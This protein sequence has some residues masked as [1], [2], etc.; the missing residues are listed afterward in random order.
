MI[1]GIGEL[2]GGITLAFF[3]KKM[4]R[5]VYYNTAIGFCFILCVFTIWVGF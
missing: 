4:K 5:L 2:A 3:A 1:E